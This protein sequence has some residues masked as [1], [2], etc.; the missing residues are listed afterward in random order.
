[1][2]KHSAL[3]LKLIPE[4]KEKYGN[5]WDKIAD[6]RKQLSE[7]SNKNFALGMNRLATPKYFFIADEVIEIAEN[8]KLPESERE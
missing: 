5:L 7:I 1:M 4:L 8:L 3:R 2:K 6:S